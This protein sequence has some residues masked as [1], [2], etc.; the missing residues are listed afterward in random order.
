[1][2]QALNHLSRQGVRYGWDT[3][4]IWLT[5]CWTF[6]IISIQ[7]SGVSR[8]QL[9]GCIDCVCCWFWSVW[10]ATWTRRAAWEV[11]CRP[12]RLKSYIPTSQIHHQLATRLNSAAPTADDRQIDSYGAKEKVACSCHSRHRA[13]HQETYLDSIRTTTPG[14]TNTSTSSCRRTPTKEYS[15]WQ[16]TT[17]TWWA[18]IRAPVCQRFPNNS[19]K[20][21]LPRSSIV[22]IQQGWPESS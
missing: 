3:E 11:C 12:D 10:V 19:R 4:K 15:C 8:N 13:C 5:S 22:V 17:Y 16:A 14:T 9:S 1:M 6:L 18:S 2:Q 21:N 20:V 7:H